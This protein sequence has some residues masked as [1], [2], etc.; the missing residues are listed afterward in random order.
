MIYENVPLADNTTYKIGGSARFY[1]EP[2]TEKDIIEAYGTAQECGVPVF[3]LG[4]GS[5]VLISDRGIDALVIN[6]SARFSD[7]GWNGLTANALAGYALDDL[8]AAAAQ[9]GCAG[10]EELA[11]IPG[12]VG[13]GVVMNAGAF[14][15]EVANTLCSV[16]L[17]CVPDLTVSTVQAC[18]LS[19]GYRTS[20]LKGSEDVVLSAQFVF[21]AISADRLTA[22]RERTLNTRREKQPLDYPSCGSVFKRPPGNYAGTLI[23]ACGLKGYRVGDAAVSDKHANFIVNT[24]NAKAEDVRAV[25]RH[26]QKTVYEDKGVLLEPEVIFV[27]EFADELFVPAKTAHLPE[28]P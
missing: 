18:D 24:D 3:V 8:V 12:T 14:D 22:V 11:G 28:L 26:V 4:R 19:F 21:Q 6:L 27:G 2:Y 13:G 15:S 1:T 5:N 25:I 7:I 16:R 17:L 20:A 23:Q 9:R 10:I